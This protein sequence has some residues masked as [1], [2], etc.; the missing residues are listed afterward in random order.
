MGHKATVRN[1]ILTL[2][3][4]VTL[5]LAAACDISPANPAPTPQ[6]PTK[7]KTISVVSLGTPNIRIA[8]TH[9][10]AGTVVTVVGGGFPAGAEVDIHIGPLNSGATSMVYAAT[11]AGQHG[12]I[13]ASFVM[14]AQWPNG[15]P[16]NIS[17]VLVIA[18]TP[19]FAD[20]ATTPFAYDAF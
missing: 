17:Q 18:A 9:G 7:V 4:I 20:K 15:E 11:E 1:K 8:P 5:A 13:Q 10:K 12:N 19:D 3:A 2:L 16:I 6:T 14:P